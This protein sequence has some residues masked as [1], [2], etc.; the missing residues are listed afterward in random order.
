MFRLVRL[1]PTSTS[2]VYKVS[3]VKENNDILEEHSDHGRIQG[4]RLR[5]CQSTLQ[6]FILSE[7]IRFMQESGQCN[8]TSKIS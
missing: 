3:I 2:L 6:N 5:I 7:N 8:G 4:V 1:V